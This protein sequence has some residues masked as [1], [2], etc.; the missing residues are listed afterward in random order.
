MSIFNLSVLGPHTSRQFS[1]CILSLALAKT[2]RVKYHV[3]RRGFFLSW[4]SRQYLCL[5][6]HKC[7]ISSLKSF[8]EVKLNC[9]ETDLFSIRPHIASIQVGFEIFPGRIFQKSQ[10]LIESNHRSGLPGLRKMV[11]DPFPDQ[12][13]SLLAVNDTAL[14]IPD[15]K[16]ETL[17]AP[18]SVD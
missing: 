10:S 18:A 16:P 14:A 6:R 15:I 2:L 5:F 17:V 1:W 13:C 11:L 8:I 3:E 7:C 4:E 9:D 12:T